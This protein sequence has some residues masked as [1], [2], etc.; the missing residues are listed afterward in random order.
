MARG[1]PAPVSAVTSIAGF[2][3]AGIRARSQKLLAPAEQLT[4]MD[5]SGPRGNLGGA[6]LHLNYPFLRHHRRRRCTEV[7]TSTCDLVYK[8]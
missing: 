2:D 6:G 5:P 4:V 3:A 8:D 1:T 7:I